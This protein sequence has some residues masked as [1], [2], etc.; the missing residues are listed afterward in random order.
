LFFIPF[1]EVQGIRIGKF[2]DTSVDPQYASDE[3]IKRIYSPEAAAKII[4]RRE[5]VSR[6]EKAVK[7]DTRVAMSDL[8]VSHVAVTIRDWGLEYL[9]L[10]KQRRGKSQIVIEPLVLRNLQK[11]GTVIHPTVSLEKFLENA[12]KVTGIKT[13]H[14]EKYKCVYKILLLF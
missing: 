12:L 13:E 2:K 10:S 14:Q 1:Y 5:R 3:K 11:A 4:Q 9:N 8:I 7:T 6:S